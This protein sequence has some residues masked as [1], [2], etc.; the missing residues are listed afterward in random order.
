ML[1][2]VP[3]FDRPREK[4]LK[5]GV[6]SLSTVELIAILLRTGNKEE[7]VIDLS[8][9]LLYGLDS[10]SRL[11][12]MT[13][14][15]LINLKGIG[16][17]KAI[18]LQASIELGLR[19]LEDKNRLKKYKSSKQIFDYYS[20]LLKNTNKECLYAIFL[21]TK[22]FVISEQLITQG[23]ISSSLID[24]RD[25]IKWALKLSASAIILVHNHPSGD[26][27]PSVADMKVT[28]DFIKQAKMMDL[29]ILDHIIV[30]NTYFS[31]RENKIVIKE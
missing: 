24:G 11:R 28:S 17:T 7:S 31:M 13:I 26:P 12:E 29:V 5:Y 23:T 9:R 4:A 16:S 19:I 18:T 27:T 25:I 3:F 1:R 14:E 22:G 20:P 8:K 21:N 2:E 6:K 10:I 30:G 15:E